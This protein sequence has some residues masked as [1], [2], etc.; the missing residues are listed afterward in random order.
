MF[1]QYHMVSKESQNPHSWACCLLWVVFQVGLRPQKR[2]Y[3][4][5]Y[6]RETPELAAFSMMQVED[7]PLPSHWHNWV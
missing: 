3:I 7:M 6:T 4:L 2:L 1:A 5:F